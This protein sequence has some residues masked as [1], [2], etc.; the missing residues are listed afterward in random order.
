MNQVRPADSQTLRG[1][2]TYQFALAALLLGA[3]LTLIGGCETPSPH[4]ISRNYSLRPD[5]PVDPPGAQSS[6]DHDCIEGGQLYKYYCGSCH[7]ARPLG[8]RP[9][10][11][12]HVALTHMRGQAYLTGQEYRQIM[13]FLRR[14]HDVG[15][16]TPPVT[17]SPK[18]MIFSQ[19]IAELRKDSSDRAPA[20]PSGPGPFQAPGGANPAP[21]GPPGAPARAALPELPAPIN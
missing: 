14:W 19:P 9:F 11:N 17:P 2:H 13:V 10:S 1:E 6:E 5:L 20:P 3:S 18:R 4:T 15:P 16:P 8:E 7:N 21:G 12:Y